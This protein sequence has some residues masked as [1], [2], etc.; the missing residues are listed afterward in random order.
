MN[1][2]EMKSAFVSNYIAGWNAKME[3][4]SDRVRRTQTKPH[5]EGA[6]KAHMTAVVCGKVQEPCAAGGLE[7]EY[8][9]GFGAFLTRCGGAVLQRYG[10][11]RASV[12]TT[13]GRDGKSSDPEP[14]V[15]VS[16]STG[17][18]AVTIEEAYSL[19][20]RELQSWPT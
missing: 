13:I 18:A 10:G 20:A 4:A 3:T 17:P 7:P 8:A 11:V 9:T 1:A 14:W 12:A 19:G 5:P 15:M 6:W 16:L 2:Q